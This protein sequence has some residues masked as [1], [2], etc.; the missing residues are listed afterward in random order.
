MT[1]EEWAE[2]RAERFSLID[3]HPTS[4]VYDASLHYMCT[5]SGFMGITLA[6][7]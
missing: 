3:T 5:T 2:H 6:G 7:K 4:V 1:P